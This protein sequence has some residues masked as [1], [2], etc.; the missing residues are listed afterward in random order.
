M[1]VKI[2][3]YCSESSHLR[4]SFDV[5]FVTAPEPTEGRLF[6]PV[7]E[8]PLLLAGKTSAIHM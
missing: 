8:V 1:M 5:I 4:D 3:D 7:P 6:Y 2:A